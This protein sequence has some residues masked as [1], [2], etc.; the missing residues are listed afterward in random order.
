MCNFRLSIECHEF[1]M[2]IFFIF[3]IF[4]HITGKKKQIIKKET[5]NEEK[6]NFQSV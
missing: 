3:L 4:F 2:R 1:L 6:T 5:Q